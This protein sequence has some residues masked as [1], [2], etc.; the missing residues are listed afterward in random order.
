MKLC[1]ARSVPVPVDSCCPVISNYLLVDLEVNTVRNWNRLESSWDC[2]VGHLEGAAAAA[3]GI[4]GS[5]T[6]V[7]SG[8]C[9][10]GGAA[11]GCCKQGREHQWE[12]MYSLW[13]CSLLLPLLSLVSSQSDSSWCFHT[14]SYTEA[15]LILLMPVIFA[16][17]ATLWVLV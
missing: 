3:C 14:M 8:G 6:E 15:G 16:Q 13:T 10:A 9:P 1:T 4:W 11:M 12:L 5:A 7:G 2:E 17:Q